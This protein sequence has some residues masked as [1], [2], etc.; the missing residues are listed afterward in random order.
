[1]PKNKN[2]RM[3]KEMKKE[4]PDIYKKMLLDRNINWISKIDSYLDSEEVEF[5]MVGALH[6]P[7][8][9]GVLEMLREQGYELSQL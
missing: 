6:L 5:V 4:Y 7:G 3:Q 1:M 9:E 2:N 8:P